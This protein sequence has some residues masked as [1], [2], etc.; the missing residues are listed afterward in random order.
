MKNI[1]AHRA[2][3]ALQLLLGTQIV[4]GVINVVYMLPI[5]SAV[6]H[7]GVGVLVLAATIVLTCIVAGKRDFKNV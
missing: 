6:L 2:I 4:L 1:Y 3:I 5:E 7:N